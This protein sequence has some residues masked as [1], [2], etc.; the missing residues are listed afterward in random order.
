M[1]ATQEKHE[2]RSRLLTVREAAAICRV[3]LPHLY[4]LIG[5]GELPAIRVGHGTGPL[6]IPERELDEWLNE[7]RTT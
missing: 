2:T 7:R 1:A 4:R 3:S 6:R 5:A